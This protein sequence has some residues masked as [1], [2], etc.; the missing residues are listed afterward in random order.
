MKREERRERREERGEKRGER[1]DKREEGEEGE[2]REEREEEREERR[3]E[4]Q[5]NTHINALTLLTRQ[6]GLILLLTRETL[7]STCSTPRC[8][9]AWGGGWTTI[10]VGEKNFSPP[11]F[12]DVMA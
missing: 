3:E 2:E 9:L 10:R 12:S 11:Y 8:G 6:P 1:S 5:L 7:E 4:T